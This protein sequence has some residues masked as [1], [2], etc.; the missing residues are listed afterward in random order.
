MPSAEESLRQGDTAAALQ[1]LT[2]Q[3]RRQPGDARLRV[4]LS[5]L[6]M[7]TGQWER[8]GNQLGVAAELDAAAIPMRQIY[9][10]AI[11]CEQLRTE[12]FAGHKA[13]MVF[14][15]PEQW[16]AL[17]IEALLRQG[18]GEDALAADL[19][20]RAFDEAPAS[21]GAI[22]GTPFAWIADADM[23]L[24]PVLEAVIN[25][26]Y[27][28]V[29]FAQLLQ[30]DIEAPEDLRDVVWSPAH[31]K[32]ANGGEALALIPARYPG[33]HA[34]GDGALQ[35]ARKTDWREPRPGFFEGIG[36]RLFSTDAG[37]RALLETRC[38][39]LQPRADG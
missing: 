27:Y 19:S 8:A 26:R 9:S 14:G 16:L 23:R 6:L 22:D 36:Q 35:L 37:D 39:V 29:P 11:R 13:P 31:F 38:I 10:D 32:F 17:L 15:Q 4:F 30:V 5:Q 12:V 24:G 34:A 7:V 1:Q 25:G 28:W 3:V 20:A 21:A 2:E 18:Q 33:S